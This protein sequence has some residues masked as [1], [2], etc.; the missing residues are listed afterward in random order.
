MIP[1]SEQGA[2]KEA[3]ML[4]LKKM[5]RKVKQYWRDSREGGQNRVAT[6]LHIAFGTVGH[7]LEKVVG[8]D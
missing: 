8:K 5:K 4:K 1:S 3:F 7:L 6:C 2:R